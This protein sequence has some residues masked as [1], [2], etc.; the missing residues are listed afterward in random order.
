M[1]SVRCVCG[2]ALWESVGGRDVRM[3]SGCVCGTVDVAAGEYMYGACLMAVVLVGVPLVR[4]RKQ[5]GPS[6][7][8]IFLSAVQQT[9]ATHGLLPRRAGGRNKAATARSRMVEMK[10]RR[11]K[12]KKAERWRLKKQVGN[13]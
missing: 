3:W 11:G 12:K 5:T 9:E 10:S 1:K 13:C 7:V 2:C 4:E 6:L 8:W